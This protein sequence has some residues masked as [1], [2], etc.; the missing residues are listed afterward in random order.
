MA[1]TAEK[2]KAEGNVLY[3]ARHLEEALAK[4]REAFARNASAVYLSN[5]VAALFESGRKAGQDLSP[6]RTKKAL[7]WAKA[8]FF[9]GDFRACL[10]LASSLSGAEA[11]K[12]ASDARAL[13][14]V[15][16]GKPAELQRKLLVDKPWFRLQ[17]DTTFREL[18]TVGHDRAFSAF[19]GDDLKVPNR[20]EGEPRGFDP[21]SDDPES[22]CPVPGPDEEPF[23][24][25]FGGCNDARHMLLSLLDMSRFVEDPDS[26]EDPKVHFVLNDVKYPVLARLAL[27]LRI[28]R[29]LGW[30]EPGDELL[31][32][33][34]QHVRGLDTEELEDY[35]GLFV[36][37]AMWNSDELARLW[38]YCVVTNTTYLGA[39]AKI[40]YE[41][42]RQKGIEHEA[43]LFQE[44]FSEFPA[45]FFDK[46]FAS[47]PGDTMEGEK[48]A[49]VRVH[50]RGDKPMSGF[51]IPTWNLLR[52]E[53]KE[54]I[55]PISLIK[56][57]LDK[58][59][60]I[61]L[62]DLLDTDGFNV[63]AVEAARQQALDLV[64]K[65]WVSNPVLWESEIEDK[66]L[67]WNPASAIVA[68]PPED[69]ADGLLGWAMHWFKQVAEAA[70]ACRNVWRV[71]F[72]LGDL[73]QT[74]EQCRLGGISFDRIFMSNVPDYT[75]SLVAHL[76]AART[77][78]RHPKAYFR[79]NVLLNN[80]YWKSRAHALNAT[81][82]IQDDSMYPKLL[83]T[84]H[85]SGELYDDLKYAALD[86]LAPADLA[87]PADVKTWLSR[88]LLSILA[89]PMRE[90]RQG[91]RECCP[92][93]IHAW[94]RAVEGLLEIGYPKHLLVP[95]VDLVVAAG[96]RTELQARWPEES[97]TPLSLSDPVP[98]RSF[99]LTPFRAD[100][101]AAAASWIPALGLPV[102]LRG[103]EMRPIELRMGL[104]ATFMPTTAWEI[105]RAGFGSHHNPRAEVLG[106]LFWNAR[107]V[108]PPAKIRDEIVLPRDYTKGEL[109]QLVSAYER[110]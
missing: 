40:A 2:L 72:V 62:L 109:L 58:T 71:S 57:E 33:L 21:F 42:Q 52:F 90:S 98:A 63:V 66:G 11:S 53:P 106:I 1:T 28:L 39:P 10:D 70:S 99:D 15:S 12:L 95:I 105:M 29:R 25:F 108:G 5:A 60:H 44:R 3:A 89:P 34:I 67:D 56:R 14:S 80:S 100:I 31:V 49:K 45:S 85:L 19:A 18:Y 50:R 16:P 7:R 79:Y 81:T 103:T 68:P 91:F 84:R 75:S 77:L 32:A 97:P 27:M 76:C 55:E 101:R 22:R 26:Y 74:L 93:S 65:H 20:D 43:K 86:P 35:T 73:S 41:A 47:A 107:A 96:Q 54:L 46:L 8:L 24:L 87:S 92:N 64:L 102:N 9:S 36:D 30:L 23:E 38:D 61:A 6:L 69:R 59:Y 37:E 88:L 51:L 83:G 78:K 17:E 94:F 82:L 104:D 110:R 13:E 4:Y 48:A